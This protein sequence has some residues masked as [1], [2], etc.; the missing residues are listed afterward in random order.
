M[1]SLEKISTTIAEAGKLPTG[2]QSGMKI[3]LFGMLSHSER[4]LKEMTVPFEDAPEHI[5]EQFEDRLQD[6][7]PGF[8]AYNLEVLGEH[9][10]KLQKAFEEGDAKTVRKFFDLYIFH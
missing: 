2:N 8:H 6:L 1:T 10:K 9:L 3:D 4:A 7:Q 5:V